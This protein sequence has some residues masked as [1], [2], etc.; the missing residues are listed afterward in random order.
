MVKGVKFLSRLL[1][2]SCSD[3]VTVPL[4]FS[5]SLACVAS[6]SA[7]GSSRKVETREKKRN[8][9]EG[10][11]KEGTPPPS[12][13]NFRAITRLET[14]AT[15]ATLPA[16]PPPPPK[17]F[18]DSCKMPARNAKRSNSIILRKNRGMWTV[19]LCATQWK[20]VT[21]N[22]TK[23]NKTKP[24]PESWWKDALFSPAHFP[25]HLRLCVLNFFLR[26]RRGHRL[27]KPLCIHRSLFCFARC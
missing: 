16:K 15:Q 22:K 2:V 8:D 6:V 9:G 23:Q 13:S 7:R 24:H 25:L 1:N 12:T 26:T 10:E 18:W 14:L 4:F 20:A 17:W 21:E 27:I 19:Y 11:G 3:V 5:L